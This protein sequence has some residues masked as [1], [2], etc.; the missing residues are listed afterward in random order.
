LKTG[1]PAE[2][3]SSQTALREVLGLGE[4][5]L[6][7]AQ[8]AATD[9]TSAS[10]TLS[11]QCGLIIQTTARLAGGKVELWLSEQVL[12][13]FIGKAQGQPG[14]DETADPPSAL[15][16]FCLATLQVCGAPN[17]K[18]D[19]FFDVYEQIGA[20]KSGAK[21]TAT[22][23]A[24][25]VAAPLLVQDRAGQTTALLGVL[26]AD[27]SHGSPFTVS[28]IRLLEG[29]ASQSALALQS[30]L[31]MANER[32]RREQLSLVQQVSLQIADLR[33]L[34]E[35]ARQVTHLILQTFGFYYVAIFTLP[36]GQDVL[37]FRASAGPGPLSDP[38]LGGRSLALAI[39]LGQG[40]IGHVAQSGQEILAR[41]VSVDSFYQHYD[42]L[43]ETRSEVALP[44]IVQDRLLGVLDV[45]SDQVDD[46][47]E[48]DMLV[49]RA[50]AGNIAM[51]IEDAQLYEALRHHAVQLE[52]VYEVSSAISSIL[53]QDKLLNEV[54]E[55]IHKRFDYPYVH[56][57]TVHP[58][59]GKILYEAGS[60]PRSQVIRKEEYFYELD[61]PQGI[62]PWVARNG[63][64]VLAND[65][66][67]E[68]RFRPSKLPPDETLS[69]LSVPLIFGR[70]VLGVL[71]VQSDKLNA[72][73]EEDRFLFAALAEHIAIA[74]RNANLYRSETWRRQVADSLREVAGLLSADLDLDQVL[75]AVL[76]ELE[77]T[78][79]LDVA[80]IWLLSESSGDEDSG[81]LPSLHLAAVRG[82]GTF[83]LEL[84]I[85]LLPEEVLEYNLDAPDEQKL[86]QASAW[87]TEALRSDI[88]VT[89][90]PSSPFDPLGAALD[91]P[92][93]YSA[94]A[95]PLR[96]G[97]RLLGVLTLAHRTAG[98]YGSESQTMTA[99]FASYASVALENARLYEEAHEQAWVSTVLLQVAE[100]TQSVTNL[101]EL[102]DTVIR[103]TPMLAGVKACLL[104]ILDEDGAFVP[105]AASGLNPDQQAEFERWRFAPGDVAALDRLMEERAPVILHEGQEDTRLLSILSTIQTKEN[106]K[107]VKL[108]V[109][110]PLLARGEVLGVF[111]V[112]YTTGL[113]TMEMGKSLEAFFDERLAILQGIAHQTAVAVDNI[114][115]L[116]A[117]KEEAYVSVALLQVAQAVVSSNDLEEALGSIVRITPILVGV[118]RAII[119]LWD[120]LQ[121]SF[122]MSQSYGIARSAA[123]QSYAGQSYA[124]GEFPLLDAALL[125]D[126]LVACPLQYGESDDDVPGAWTRLEAPDLDRQDEYLKDAA[127]LLIAFPL[128]MKGKVLGVFLVEEP[129]PAPGESSSRNAN[130]RL[131]SKRLEIITGISQQAALAIQ[132]DLLQ[133]EMVERERLEREM[134]LA[135]EIQRA[136]LPHSLPQLP[137]WELQ[138]NW[139]PAR[140][141]GGD[142]YDYFELPDGHFGLVIADVADKGMPAALFMTLVRTLVRA[143][144]RDLASPAAVLRRV[145]NLIVPDA[146]GGMFVTLAYAVL[147]LKTGELTIANAGHN[148]PLWLQRRSCQ[149]EDIQRTGMALGVFEN[150]PFEERTCQIARGDFLILYTDGV[151]DAFSPQGDDFGEQRLR[152]AINDAC[153]SMTTPDSPVDLT[154][155]QML[156]A[157]DQ[158]VVAFVAD[159]VPSDDLTLLV[160][161][162]L[163]S[164]KRI[165]GRGGGTPGNLRRAT[166]STTRGGRAESSN[167]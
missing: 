6:C 7:L 98:R 49:L 91:Y 35:I 131:R 40:I 4:D 132:N 41:D 148:P 115:L 71:D 56:L 46:F 107:E 10:E 138:V 22:K 93:D 150:N 92:P 125:E 97:E 83:D 151:T 121:H 153:Q 15:M 143:T 146:T 88:P 20:Q 64:T 19:T 80:A 130:R 111:L 32:W 34:D 18:S 66:R 163:P 99:A 43:P 128:A 94:I 102:L 109:L 44:L 113:P 75:E 110:V 73:G 120:E 116:K 55:L 68:P 31:R 117:Q 33:D 36:A 154:A 8:D 77:H 129:E 65:V 90:S 101:T 108:P 159:A 157:I 69:E 135:R 89:R 62:I 79:P 123:G 100:A 114:R 9:G 53:D 51:A 140:Q 119:Y 50:L 85:G 122:R 26:Q 23:K 60:G 48:S 164:V 52:A 58:D 106:A 37:H 67:Q 112:D 127:S 160:L 158:Q 54:V 16:R 81:E 74:M 1:Q 87:L 5:L 133:R 42:L 96:V 126:S 82:A 137:G 28:E 21:K 139:R 70:Q 161:K 24:R 155:Q 145:N 105:A 59:R 61:D 3:E 118:N 144:V 14:M 27:R 63:E 103:I 152:Q 38:D 165:A 13:S 124:L 134:Q 156:D 86:E 47:D 39:H 162:R 72:F 149:P 95:A 136:F 167:R 104:Y 84:E 76:T 30:S 45:Q 17:S 25:L 78:L 2:H 141:V 12:R 142:F 166:G 11:A 57:F 147:D 29:L